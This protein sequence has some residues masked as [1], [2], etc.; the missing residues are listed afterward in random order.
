[1]D[2]VLTMQDVHG[3][4]LLSIPNWNEIPNGSVFTKKDD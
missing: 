1:M 2:V 4:R 3:N